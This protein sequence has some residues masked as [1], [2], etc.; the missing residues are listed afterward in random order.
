M[1][2]GWDDCVY[3]TSVRGRGADRGGRSHR[4]IK[5]PQQ[6]L[7]G[8]F[9]TVVQR[10][11]LHRSHET[12][13]LCDGSGGAAVQDGNSGGAQLRCSV[14]GKGTNCF[15]LLTL[16]DGPSFGPEAYQTS[17]V[18]TLGLLPPSLGR[19]GHPMTTPDRPTLDSARPKSQPT[20]PRAS[21][22]AGLI[23]NTIIVV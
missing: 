23:G 10:P 7:T 5:S 11:G 19:G 3:P 16:A 17:G 2:R 21:G 14:N 18:S 4:C 1:A 6:N 15:R 8:R 9:G 13:R 20:K 12:N 22:R